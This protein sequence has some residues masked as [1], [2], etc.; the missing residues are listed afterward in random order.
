MTTTRSGVPGKTGSAALEADLAFVMFPTGWIHEGR[1]AEFRQADV[2]ALKALF[3][4]AI[5][6]G[7]LERRRESTH[8][9][10]PAS[11]A[12]I[13][14]AA[15]LSR[16]DAVRGVRTLMERGIIERD[17]NRGAE[18]GAHPRTSVFR[19]AGKEK[20]YFPFPFA[21][22]EKQRLLEHLRRGAG[23]LA[24]LQTY[25]L[26]GAFRDNASGMSRLGY[27]KL[28]S[29]GVRREHIHRGLMVLC[30]AG[31][32][33]LYEAT[34]T[35]RYPL[36]FLH[37]IRRRPPANRPRQTVVRTYADAVGEFD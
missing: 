25:L 18:F 4:L 5:M 12:E 26:L 13:A 22:F 29:Y 24:A 20:P 32:V 9:R 3:G 1:L 31:V 37:G 14:R 15:H 16:N 36:Y 19:F 27:D 21:F 8:Q 23:A 30:Q 33:T 17:E 34:E 10:F 6:R 35:R 28:E 11:V 2:W 7:T